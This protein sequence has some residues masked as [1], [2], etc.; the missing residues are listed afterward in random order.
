MAQRGD[1]FELALA[2]GERFTSR[3]VVVAI[4]VEHFAYV[5]GP[6]SDL[7]VSA[8]THSS[9]H[10]DLAAFHGREV[11]VVGAGQSALESAALLHESGATVQ[12][13]ARRPVSHPGTARPWIRAVP[14]GGG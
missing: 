11:A 4:G 8:C 12:V 2:D 1:G 5:P 9:A 3:T 13:L 10:T 7:P 14:C 6:L